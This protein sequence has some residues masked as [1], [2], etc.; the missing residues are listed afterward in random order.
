MHACHLKMPLRNPRRA[1][2]CG[3]DTRVAIPGSSVRL[4]RPIA[5]GMNSGHREWG[6]PSFPKSAWSNR[7]QMSR[8]NGSSA[9]RFI[10]TTIRTNTPR[11][12]AAPVTCAR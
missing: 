10:H 1:T 12:Q 11:R 5:A 7:F 3:D 6:Y 4:F 9:F 8:V 2:L